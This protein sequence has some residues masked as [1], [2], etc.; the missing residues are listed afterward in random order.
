M[1]TIL[2][3]I[4]KIV[5]LVISK[6]IKIRVIL[7]LYN[8]IF[9]NSTFLLVRF[10]VMYVSL[11]SIDFIWTIKL[12]NGKKVKTSVFYNN[13][14][15]QQFA[16]SYK[17]HSPS[18]NKTEDILL[19]FTSPETVWIDIGANMGLRSLTG[20]S[21][22]RNV[23]FIEPNSEVNS[24]NKERCKLNHFTNFE[25]IEVGM[26]DIKGVAEFRIDSSSYNSTIENNQ[27]ND[28]EVERIE[29]INIDTLDNQAQQKNWLKANI[30]IDVEGHELKVLKGAE[31]FIRK[32][33]PNIV[34]EVN[35]KGDH[36]QRFL[37]WAFNYNYKVF[38]IGN[39]KKGKYYR[40]INP[41]S[42]NSSVNDFLLTSDLSIIKKLTPYMI[43]N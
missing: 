8:L 15:T 28:S 10:F 33:S 22:N 40:E 12:L 35:E 27:L 2:K 16:L 21:M 34:I 36:F 3:F 39:F 37:E 41:K 13:I 5:G 14:L 9:E 23:V 17:W 6:A 30:K 43:S 7:K 20:L 32:T 26:S 11:P 29:R 4:I 25:F 31:N 24:I 18:L 42:H 38:E 19:S 1:K